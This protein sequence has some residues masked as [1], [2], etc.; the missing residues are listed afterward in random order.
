M[1]F[2]GNKF[3]AWSKTTAQPE[4]VDMV[5]SGDVPVISLISDDTGQRR[6]VLPLQRAP[7]T[8]DSLLQRAPITPG[9]SVAS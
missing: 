7:I 3:E 8:R 5:L 2:P 9:Q 4:S 6:P 1:M